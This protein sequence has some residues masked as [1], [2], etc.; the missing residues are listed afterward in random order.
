MTSVKRKRPIN[1]FRVNVIEA[2]EENGAVAQNSQT[3]A[4]DG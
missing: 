1:R 2:E 3:E 4:F